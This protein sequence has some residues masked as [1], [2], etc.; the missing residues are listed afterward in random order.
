[1]VCRVFA[2]KLKL[3]VL[4]SL[5]FFLEILQKT[6]IC[7]GKR[8]QVICLITLTLKNAM[9]VLRQYR[10]PLFV[11]DLLTNV[12]RSPVDYI[13]FLYVISAKPSIFE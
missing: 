2:F 6:D 13:L 9:H 8:F 3:S 1:M 7:K 11:L 12:E 4:F 5:H 10:K